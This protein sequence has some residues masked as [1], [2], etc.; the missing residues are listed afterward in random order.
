MLI[1]HG[2]PQGFGNRDMK[3][4]GNTQIFLALAL[5]AVTTIVHSLPTTIVDATSSTEVVAYNMAPKQGTGDYNAEATIVGDEKRTCSPEPAEKSYGSASTRATPNVSNGVTVDVTL[6][7]VV[8]A[9]GGRYS[10]CNRCDTRTNLCLDPGPEV[11]TGAQATAT[12]AAIAT[13]KFPQD[14]RGASAYRLRVRVISGQGIGKPESLKF[15]LE[16]G[17]VPGQISL[18]RNSTTYLDISPGED[19]VVTATLRA[20]TRIAGADETRK[21]ELKAK[22]RIEL[23]E[24]PIL[25][26]A[27]QQ[28][29]LLNGV[30]TTG[31]S[32]VGLLAQLEDDGS[33]KPH[34][35]GSV[36]GDRSILTAA[37]CVGDG[38][39]KGVVE[40]G[41]LLFLPVS[42][43]ENTAN[44]L[45]VKTFIFPSGEQ[46][47]GLR[48]NEKPDK[49]LEDDVAILFTDG[50]IG[51]P[52]LELY[53]A[54]PPL[55]D[56]VANSTPVIFVGYGFNPSPTTDSR[57]LGVKREAT[58]PISNP[59]NRTFLVSVQHTGA[60]TC[61]GDSGGPALIKIGTDYKILGITSYG[62]LNCRT[63]RSMRADFYSNWIRRHIQ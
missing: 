53:A 23:D 58:G 48:F 61:R 51:I 41:R 45:I 36:I 44:P 6:T 37:H 40:G 27:A 39:M 24:A 49:S 30:P 43:I 13:Y 55:A 54:Q 42:S 7:A 57:R 19:V 17:S 47:E 60:S 21:E 52:K 20:E 11:P 8:S 63:G 2:W 16:R 32:A 25:E 62:A 10:R 38:R 31:F 59:D 33:A 4:T 26:G 29:Y 22:L 46:P 3:Q 14:M 5:S 15:E 35:T 18:E 34:C 1:G 9:K 56:I 50:P 12:T 28:G